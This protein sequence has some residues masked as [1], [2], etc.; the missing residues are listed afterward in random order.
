[1]RA[2]SDSSAVIVW[3]RRDL[4]LADNPALARAAATGLPIAF[5]YI[6]DELCEKAW[7]SG[8]ASRWWL[9]HSLRALDRSLRE[10]GSRLLLL[11][12]EASATLIRLCH[13]LGARE[14]FWNRQFE[15]ERLARDT[16]VKKSLAAAGIQARSFNGSLLHAP[17]QVANN[18]GQP[19]KVFTPFWNRI[20]SLP[21]RRLE[22]V[23]RELRSLRPLPRG[24]SIESL[25]LLAS[26]ARLN[27][28]SAW[29]QPG[30]SNA[31]AALE[32]FADEKLQ[33]YSTTRDDPSQ[34]GVSRLSPRL[35]FGELSP[36]QVWRQI[37]GKPGSEA[38]LRQLVWRE[39]G[40]HLLFHYPETS[41]RPMRSE[42][43][44][45][46]WQQD[47]K[48]LEAW[49]R[50]QTGYPLVDAGMRELW[51]TGWMHNRVRMIAASFLVKHLL[52]PWQD[53]AAW[54]WDTL[55]DADLA[56][57]TLGWQWVAGCG[58]DA[59]PYFR[60]FNP[61]AQGKR[62]DAKGEYTRRWAP[63]LA[64]LPDRHLFSPWEASS[65][66]LRQAG[67]KLGV[68]YPN[69]LVSHEEARTRALAA[70]KVMRGKS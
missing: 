14:V 16:S 70:Y 44:R 27:G 1:M 62:F 45:F 42:F 30:E 52:Q 48:L 3:F 5:V 68:D 49:K 20:R 34:F 40:S 32:A 51:S 18:S 53:G 11:R 54:F 60:I 17:N 15:P 13:R 22:P 61:T 19:Y 46:P 67:I 64:R 56:N 28:F 26:D 55:V 23:S 31:R 47:S 33:V 25:G 12:G 57:N 41:H 24:E 21:T 36:V 58:A 29:W 69:P 35:H 10:L 39:F 66:V 8:A 6:H 37:D 65:D 7:A 50:G 63:E 59:A 43:E 9:H 2:M 38:F 4:R